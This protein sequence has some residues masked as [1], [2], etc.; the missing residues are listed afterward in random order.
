MASSVRFFAVSED[1]R[2]LCAYLLDHTDFLIYE[3]YS[4]IDKPLRILRDRRS[5]DALIAETA[6]EGLHLRLVSPSVVSE[7]VVRRFELSAS[8]GGGWRSTLEDPS[9]VSIVQRAPREDSGT[10]LVHRTDWN[11]WSEKGARQRSVWSDARLD[12][13]NWR[14]LQKFSGRVQYH[15]RR[16]IAVARLHGWPVLANAASALR[17]GRIH[18]W[19]EDGK[20]PV[21]AESQRLQWV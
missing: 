13:V 12:A 10:S 6:G 20:G 18:L 8:V 4:R 11:H 1:L 9:M 16:R 15:L 3:A 19:A 5:V 14:E 17:A 21:S 2:E 7:P